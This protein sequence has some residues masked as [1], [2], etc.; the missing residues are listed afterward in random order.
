MNILNDGESIKI[1]N[2]WLEAF[3]TPGHTLESTCYIL[4]NKEG[5]KEAVYSGDTVFIGEVGRPDLA[6]KSNVKPEELAKILYKSIQK[7]KT[8]PD[9]L[10]VYPNHGAGSSCGKN[11]SH[12]DKTTVGCEK[13]KN[14]AFKA[15]SEEEFVRQVLKD[16][17]QPPNYYF[18]SVET[19][20]QHPFDFDQIFHKSFKPLTPEQF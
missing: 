2:V 14:Y 3:H 7:F 12:G 16:M 5:L 19:N 15:N 8:L 4:K 6:A 17:P 13:A 20:K 18:N 1:G 11:M 9:T 10:T